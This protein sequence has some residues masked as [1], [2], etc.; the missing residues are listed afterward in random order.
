MR[1]KVDLVTMFGERN[2][3]SLGHAGAG[4]M[5][6]DAWAWHIKQEKRQIIEATRVKT[7]TQR[8]YPEVAYQLA[9]ASLLVSGVS[10]TSFPLAT[11][12]IALPR[13]PPLSSK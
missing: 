8:F 13:G 6:S 3:S 9:L 2:P 10:L 12:S 5:L 4:K 1:D 7:R 11:Q